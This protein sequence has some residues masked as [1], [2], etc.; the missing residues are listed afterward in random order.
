MTY[1]GYTGN[2]TDFGIAQVFSLFMAG[3]SPRLDSRWFPHPKWVLSIGGTMRSKSFAIS[4]VKHQLCKY[5][6]TGMPWNT[7]RNWNR[8]YNSLT[9]HTSQSLQGSKVCCLWISKAISIAL[10]VPSNI[11]L[12]GRAAGHELHPEFFRAWP[13]DP[14]Y[15]SLDLKIFEARWNPMLSTDFEETLSMMLTP[16]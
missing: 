11:F 8:N 14:R 12:W 16:E 9:C 7:W 5:K 10:W 3:I 4:F 6:P 1:L 2:K 13:V 15:D